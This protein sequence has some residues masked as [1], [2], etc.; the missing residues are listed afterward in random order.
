MVNL[1]LRL[2]M[3][4]LIRI[5]LALV[6]LVWILSTEF[7]TYSLLVALTL[8]VAIE[9]SDFFDG[10]IAR[11][12]NLV[13]ELGATLDPYADSA[14]RLIVYSALAFDNLALMAVPIVMAFRDVTVA[15]TRILMTR[16]GMSAS[17]N[18]SGKIKAIV[19]AVGAFLLIL[20]P[21]LWPV[22]EQNI[23]EAFLFVD[24]FKP[25][26]IQIISWIVI[27]VTLL[28]MIEYIV[29]AMPAVRRGLK[30]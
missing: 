24:L 9:L 6:F 15:Y 16:A 17:A 11:R 13:S 30:K 27:I 2:L 22:R 29:R 23:F 4:T 25:I 28:S 1:Y 19:Q 5:P 14:A 12:F 10:F 26:P 21:V 8:L 20:S 18:W 3:L 7:S